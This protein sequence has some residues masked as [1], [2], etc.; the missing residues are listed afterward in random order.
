MRTNPFIK[1]NFRKL[2]IAFVLLAL[3]V[4]CSTDITGVDQP[5]TINAGESLTAV[6]KVHLDVAG[7]NLG[8][9]LVVG[10]LVPKSWNAS[11]NT[12]VYYTCTALSA[13]NEKMSLMPASEK[14]T[15]TQISW[16]E[17]LMQDKRYALMGNLISDME[18]V[19]FRS[20]KTYDVNNS[21]DYTVKIV[22]KT[23][24]QNMLVNLGYFVGNTYNGLEAPGS[25]KYHD[26]KSARLSV[27]NGTGDLIDFIN[28]QLAMMELSKATDNDIQTI[29]Y[30]GDLITTPLS[31]E[32]KIYLCAKGYTN[33]GQVIEQCA[34]SDKTAFKPAPGINRFR[35]DF[36]PRSF[37]GLKEDQSLTKMEY[38]LMDATGTKKVG[39]G[40]STLPSD[41]FKFTFNCQ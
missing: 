24:E 20:T 36:W 14:E 5:E 34:V 30:D 32:T 10:F 37:F 21:V 6:V 8:K 41:P 28:P 1:K 40:G 23:G 15:H 16:P 9:T 7:T 22:T 25:D 29:Y 2:L 4:A 27:I 26:G 3:V 31:P 38:F 17:A 35:F 19:V 18:W 11:K 39:Y 13:E 12:S 33:D